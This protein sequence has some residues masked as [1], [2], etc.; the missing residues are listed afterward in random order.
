MQ[1]ERLLGGASD[2][3]HPGK[4]E[5]I[6]SLI[7]VTSSQST[8][9]TDGMLVQDQAGDLQSSGSCSLPCDTREKD[10]K[11]SPHHTRSH[12]VVGQVLRQ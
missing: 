2:P 8:K 10:P 4:S 7:P 9:P 12:A 1:K 5:P 3:G 11:E 6:L